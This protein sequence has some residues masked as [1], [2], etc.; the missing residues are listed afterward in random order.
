MYY[1][2]DF[3][4]FVSIFPS[5]S[6]QLT[7]FSI[8][9]KFF[10]PSFLQKLR[11][12]CVHLF[13]CVLYPGT[14][15]LMNYPPWENGIVILSVGGSPC[16]NSSHC[17]IS[18]WLL[19]YNVQFSSLH[20]ILIYSQCMTWLVK[21]DMICLLFLIYYTVVLGTFYYPWYTASD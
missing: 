3:K 6:I 15:N 11:S 19:F 8:N 16:L 10:D 18:E 13:F 17:W 1:L 9:F 4:H 14:E 2:T 12:D 7:H 5:F 20:I 21:Y